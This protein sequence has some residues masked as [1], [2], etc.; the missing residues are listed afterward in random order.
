MSVFEGNQLLGLIERLRAEFVG[1]AEIVQRGADVLR[2]VDQTGIATSVVTAAI[3]TTVEKDTD[4]LYAAASPTRLTARV[5]GW[6]VI[7]GSTQLV[8]TSGGGAGVETLT[9][10]RI[11]GA[12]FTGISQAY[13]AATGTT[14]NTT[15]KVIFLNSGD[16]VE[17]VVQHSGVGA[18]MKI[19]A[20]GARFAMVRYP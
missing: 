10:L 7:S 12:L 8:F 11:N 13:T 16:Y 9:Y 14:Y 18:I 5:Q 17:L 1:R 15:N 6:Y 19:N 20:N 3:F 4:A 2:N